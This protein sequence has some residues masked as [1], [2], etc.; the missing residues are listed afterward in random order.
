MRRSIRIAGITLLVLAF[1]GAAMAQNANQ[2]VVGKKGIGYYTSDAPFGIRY[3]M[4]DAMAIDVGVGLGVDTKADFGSS[5]T[6]ETLLDYA[7]EVGLPWA[8][9]AK[10]T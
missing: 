10:R 7:F 9:T 1:A 2:R 6:D 4:N 8:L 5:P 3:W